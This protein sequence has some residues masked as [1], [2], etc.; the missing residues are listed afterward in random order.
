MTIYGKNI[1]V[2]KKIKH[3]P[4]ALHAEGKTPRDK[5]DGA[6]DK[7]YGVAKK[8]KCK[9]CGE[10]IYMI[11]GKPYGILTDEIGLHPDHACLGHPISVQI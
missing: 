4:K 10:L 6:L 8:R 5:V 9:F 3:K 1:Y 7:K 2:T 11:K